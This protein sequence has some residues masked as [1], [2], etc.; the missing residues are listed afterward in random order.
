MYLLKEEAQKTVPS[1]YTGSI[2]KKPKG[3]NQ[4]GRDRNKKHHLPLESNQS[5]KLTSEE[6][7]KTIDILTQDQRLHTKE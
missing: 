2:Q 5:M 6:G 3:S 4:R 7:L 1:E